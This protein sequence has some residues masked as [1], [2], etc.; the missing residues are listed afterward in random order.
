[1]QS[2]YQ[3]LSGENWSTPMDEL[4]RLTTTENQAAPVFIAC[5]FLITH[6]F[7]TVVSEG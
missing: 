4:M 3:I 2:T 6:L 5:Y 1:M 7:M